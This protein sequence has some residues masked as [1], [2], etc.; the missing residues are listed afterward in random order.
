MSE[1]WNTPSKGRC[2]LAKR[3]ALACRTFRL[4]WL[5]ATTTPVPSPTPLQDRIPSGTWKRNTLCGSWNPSTG[6]KPK[7]LKLW[8]WTGPLC[9]ANWK[10]TSSRTDLFSMQC[11]AVNVLFGITEFFAQDLGNF[12]DSQP[13][14][15]EF[16]N[17]SFQQILVNLRF[18]C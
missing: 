8:G 10:S 7:P 3:A 15:F 13:L 16:T 4:R 18:T 6:T 11:Q 2:C 17:L 12:L 5:L 9:I 14:A 1:N